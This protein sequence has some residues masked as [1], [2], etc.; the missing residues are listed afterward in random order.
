MPNNA[1]GFVTTSWTGTSTLDYRAVYVLRAIAYRDGWATSDVTTSVPF[2]LKRIIQPPYYTPNSLT[3]AS[4]QRSVST[5][6]YTTTPTTTCRYIINGGN[7][8]PASG[9]YASHDMTAVVT[10][11]RPGAGIHGVVGGPVGGT[12][13]SKFMYSL[14]SK[15][16]TL[17]R[18]LFILHY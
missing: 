2:T 15:C 14:Y 8:V 16:V 6:L 9:E 17:T 18:S 10:T 12:V 4:N 3:T 1:H 5:T 13:G 11:S 7:P